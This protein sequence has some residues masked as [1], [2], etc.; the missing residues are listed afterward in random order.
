MAGLPGYDAQGFLDAN[1]LRAQADNLGC[2]SFSRP[3]D[4]STNPLDG[5]QAV[6]ASTGRGT[7]Y[8]SDNWGTI[9]IID[10][11]FGNLSAAMLVLYDADE[12]AVPDEGIRSPDNLD[13]ADDG[14]IYLQEDRSTS[15]G[16]LFG[17]ATGVDASIWKLDPITRVAT[18]I[19]EVDRSA[20]VPANA[21]DSAAGDIG[22]WE[23]SGILDVTGFFGTA[24]RE[25]LFIAVVQAHGIRDG[26]IGGNALL[27]EGGQLVFISKTGN[28]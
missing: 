22:N 14:K 26:L 11:D 15:P 18:R 27:V 4:V 3:E 17:A 9:Y 2:F 12:L 8:P 10:V 1:T 24:S 25:R 7:Q 6:L 23:T 5:S 16:S 21:T 20:I 28:D 19:L 13:W